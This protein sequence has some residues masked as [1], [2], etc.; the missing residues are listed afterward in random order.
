M[1]RTRRSGG[2]FLCLLLNL[3]LNAEGA[4]PAVVLLGLHFWLGWSLW[5][6]V[7]ALLL[8]IT[9]LCLGTLLIRFA[10]RCGNTPAPK[11]ANKNPYS[12]KSL[13]DH[14]GDRPDE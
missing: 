12:A 8:W 1:R 3:F 10:N 7:G 9:W 13:Y 4:I 6:A 2:F 11:Q 14:P 5:W